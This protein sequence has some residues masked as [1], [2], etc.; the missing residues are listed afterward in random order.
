MKQCTKRKRAR[1]SKRWMCGRKRWFATE[2]EASEQA[3]MMAVA[4]GLTGFRGNGELRPYLCPH[5][6]R[7]HVGHGRVR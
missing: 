3:T 5:C 7:W 2:E 6:D 4:N 1:D